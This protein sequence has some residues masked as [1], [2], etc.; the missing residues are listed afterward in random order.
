MPNDKILKIIREEHG[1][2]P[3]LLWSKWAFPSSEPTK[4]RLGKFSYIKT[5]V[6][7]CFVF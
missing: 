6:D 5:T 4:E 3:V 2:V 1:K 7:F